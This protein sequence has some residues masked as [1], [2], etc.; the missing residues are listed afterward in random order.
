MRGLSKAACAAV[1]VTGLLLAG[2]GVRE[3]RPSDMEMDRVDAAL[4]AEPCI[5]EL[6]DWH[7][8]YYFHAKY[9]GEEVE[10]AAKDGRV[11]RASGQVRHIL[12]FELRRTHPEGEQ[13][14]SLPNPPK[15][16]GQKD[17]WQQEIGQG[18]VGQDDDLGVR[19]AAGTFNLR[20]GVLNMAHCD[21]EDGPDDATKAGHRVSPPLR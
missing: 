15:G 4:Q 14:I 8:S 13:R 11:P 2:C 6:V 20:T 17:M 9:F 3:M 21:A 1:L 5:G 10:K 12:G 7:R 19:R 16:T 18:D